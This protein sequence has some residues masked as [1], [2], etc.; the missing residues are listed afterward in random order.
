MSLSLL[1]DYLY[2][3][4]N[5]CHKHIQYGLRNASSWFYSIGR[6]L[7]VKPGLAIYRQVLGMSRSFMSVAFTYRQK[8]ESS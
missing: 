5:N 6:K 4:G 8:V 7:S 1:E 3:V 2:K